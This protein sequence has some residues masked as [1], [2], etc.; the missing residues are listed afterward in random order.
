MY[1]WRS[2]VDRK[3]SPAVPISFY[4][5]TPQTLFQSHISILNLDS[6][7]KKLDLAVSEG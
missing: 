1:I 4:R 3:I 2:N 5:N 7:N 6:Y